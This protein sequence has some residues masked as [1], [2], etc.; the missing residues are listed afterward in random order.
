[1]AYSV[2]VEA[3]VNGRIR[4]STVRGKN[5]QTGK[6]CNDKADLDSD[7]DL[8]RLCRVMAP[9]LDA[10]PEDLKDD[11]LAKWSHIVADRKRGQAG[12]SEAKNEVTAQVL[13]G[14]PSIIRR[15]LSLV[16]G[17]GYAA[18]WLNVQTE[19]R[20][21]V[22]PET[23]QVQR[24]DPPKRQTKPTLAIVRDDGHL[25]GDN[26][27]ITSQP[28]AKLGIEVALPFPILA[29]RA[30]SGAGV[31]RFL[32][33]DR[34]NPASIFER[35]VL[36]ADSYMD[37]TKSL[38]PQGTMCQMIACYEIGTYFLG[39]FNVIGYLWA[40]GDSGAGKTNLITIVAETGYLGM[41]ILAGGSYASLRDLADYGAVLSFDDAEGVMNVKKTD[42]DKRALLLAGNRRGATITVKE[43]APAPD[44]GWVTRYIDAF[45]PRLFSAIRLPDGVLG[46][47]SIIVPLVRS[48]DRER[49]KRNPLD[50]ASWPCDRRPLLDDLWAMGVTHVA[51]MRRWDQEAA[52][53]SSLTGRALDVWR[54]ILAVALWLQEAHGVKGL[55]ERMR[56]LSCDYQR[57]RG[58]L[59]AHESVLLAIRALQRM[60]KREPEAFEFET[61]TLTSCINVI[62]QEEDLTKPDTPYT[63]SNRVGWI[64]RK[65]RF[66]KA[67][68]RCSRKWKTTKTDLQNIAE[69]YGLGDNGKE[70]QTA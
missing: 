66:K 29:D 7:E 48:N 39:A 18:T 19:T 70:E 53:K 30:W 25:F 12:P 16:D 28:M 65:L 50:Y 63:N 59:E 43:P 4:K 32:A 54:S 44:R 67:D 11:I 40:S 33:G 31:K 1:M 60:A 41:L 51:E 20:Q 52:A 68:D 13:D 8:S 3:P 15:P 23:G 26:I 10:Q 64:L 24:F 22:N 61:K 27:P 5:E 6:T 35:L 46:S 42:P 14:S 57:E 9:K 34:P 55:H 17:R 38:A 37:F 45:C 2:L 21:T 62:A 56:Q 49:A 58:D 69:T 36:L 47:R